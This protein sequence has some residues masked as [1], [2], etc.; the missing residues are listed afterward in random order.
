MGQ[1]APD[2]LRKMT[3]HA[4]STNQNNPVADASKHLDHHLHRVAAEA[5][6]NVLRPIVDAA[7]DIAVPPTAKDASDAL[8]DSGNWLSGT[9]FAS[10]IGLPSIPCIHIAWLSKQLQPLGMANAAP[11]Q[12]YRLDVT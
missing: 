5:G 9:R 3:A 10:A 8:E 11:S 12:H 1:L 7:R 2:T 6:R 4:I